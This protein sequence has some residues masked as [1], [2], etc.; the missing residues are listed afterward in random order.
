MLFGEN[1]FVNFSILELNDLLNG[2]QIWRNL[3]GSSTYFWLIF[4][5]FGQL[6]DFAESA[7]K[8]DIGV[9]DSG[10]FLRGHGGVLDRFDSISV[11]APLTFL[12]IL[13]ID[14]LNY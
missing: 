2:I 12:Y 8:R 11:A 14:L 1:F 3:V 5:I 13:F 7:F 10:T 9:K 6:G 4:G